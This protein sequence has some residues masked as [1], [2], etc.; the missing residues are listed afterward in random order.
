MIKIL[1]GI[2]LILNLI[3]GYFLLREK[4][5][6]DFIERERL[7]IETHPREVKQEKRPINVMPVNPE[8]SNPPKE[9]KKKAD[10][11]EFRGLE[12][13]EFQDA[14]EKMENERQEFFTESLGMSEDKIAEHNRIRDEFF[15]ESTVFWK[16]NPMR[17][18]SFKERRQLLEMEETFHKKLEKLHGKKNWEKYQK[19]REDYNAKGYK[20][21]MEEG[22]PFLF[23]GL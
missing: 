22:H 4:P 10:P 8:Y 19:F 23:M 9:E 18:L 2:S 20:K 13:Y 21:Q 12:H 5:E 17:E 6:N 7:I 3:L 11:P 1:L 16:K 15:K 14:G